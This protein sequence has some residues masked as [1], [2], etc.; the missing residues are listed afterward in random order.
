MLT[1][2]VRY[3]LKQRAG[4]VIGTG[5]GKELSSRENSRRGWWGGMPLAAALRLRLS[6][7]NI[8][9]WV[10]VPMTATGSL[11]ARPLS[12]RPGSAVGHELGG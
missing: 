5:M 7:T 6:L 2:T 4:R 12:G 9:Q 11:A 10:V 1:S 8:R 3:G